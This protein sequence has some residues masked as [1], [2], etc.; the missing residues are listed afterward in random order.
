MVGEADAEEWRDVVGT[1]GKYR[2]SD[3]G[4]VAGPQ[5][6]L[7]GLISRD[8]YKRVN[9][10]LPEG[11]KQ[12]VIHKLVAESFIGQQPSGTEVQLVDGNKMNVTAAN[13]AY[14]PKGTGAAKATKS[15]PPSV[16]T[17]PNG[18]VVRVPRAYVLKGPGRPLRGDECGRARLTESDARDIL[19]AYEHHSRKGSVRKKTATLA[20]IA[21][22]YGVA[23]TTVFALVKG[24]NWRYLH[25][26]LFGGLPQSGA[27]GARK[28]LAASEAAEWAAA[29]QRIIRQTSATVRQSGSIYQRTAKTKELRI[30]DLE[31]LLD[32]LVARQGYR[33]AQTGVRFVESSAD[34]RASLDRRDSDGHYEADNVQL[35]TS[36][37]N[38]AKGKRSDSDT[39][40]LLG[41]HAGLFDSN[42]SWPPRPTGTLTLKEVLQGSTS[43]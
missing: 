6:V 13:I 2:V 37:Y 16:R 7:K 23:K 41:V 15:R 8:G 36:W 35:V 22:L 17:H 21:E 42:A 1:G 14:V 19:L 5:G 32:D 30:A 43:A 18:D 25:L 27:N 24:R 40:R 12:K 28:K 38:F 26:Q 31:K 9:L 11:Y 10:R 29:R 20:E 33:C 34:L 3:Q 39:R 4:R